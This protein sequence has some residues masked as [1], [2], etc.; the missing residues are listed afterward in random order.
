[1]IQFTVFLTTF[2]VST[3]VPCAALLEW[4]FLLDYGHSEFRTLK[5]LFVLHTPRT[6][7]C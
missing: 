1:M 6:L 4:Q 3:P 7:D 2:V 5:F